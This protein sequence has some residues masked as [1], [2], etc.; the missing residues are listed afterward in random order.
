MAI[1]PRH[2]VVVHLHLLQSNLTRA[3]IIARQIVVH[4]EVLRAQA[5]LLAL[6]N[7]Y[8]HSS[9]VH[10]PIDAIPVVVGVEGAI[11]AESGDPAR[12][13]LVRGG[14]LP[15]SFDL[16]SSCSIALLII[17]AYAVLV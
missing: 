7:R 9:G 11:F 16:V 14:H 4:A 12:F 10:L 15:Q 6:L 2:F 3:G 13:L 5:A 1:Y 17:A 8:R